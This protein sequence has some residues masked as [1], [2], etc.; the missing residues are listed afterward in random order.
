[1]LDNTA[2]PVSC[3]GVSPEQIDCDDETVL[4]VV[5]SITRITSV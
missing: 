1:M 3:A 2:F 5:T 4:E